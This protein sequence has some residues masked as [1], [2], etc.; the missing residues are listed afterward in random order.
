MAIAQKQVR[1][2][3][4]QDKIHEMLTNNG[5]VLTFSTTPYLAEL[6]VFDQA[7]WPFHNHLEVQPGD[8]LWV[9][10][11]FAVRKVCQ[12]TQGFT[13][14]IEYKDG[15]TMEL[16]ASQSSAL[17]PAGN[18]NDA[19]TMLY[20]QARL[21]LLVTAISCNAEGTEWQL[22]TVLKPGE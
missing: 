11:P 3:L 13:H 21:R 5:G 10:E 19:S 18:Y 6:Q 8:E 16:A 22:S 2:T 4:S 7:Y 9:A 14:F 15:T 12:C 20:A 17:T 1:I